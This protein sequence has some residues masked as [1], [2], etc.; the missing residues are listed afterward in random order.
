MSLTAM[1]IV[2]GLDE[3]VGV[4]AQQLL[5]RR[6]SHEPLRQEIGRLRALVRGAVDELKAAGDERAARRL[7]RALEGR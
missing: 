7:E 3:L 4:V 2:W 5:G 1:H 6:C